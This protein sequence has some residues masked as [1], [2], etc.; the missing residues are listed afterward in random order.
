MAADLGFLEALKGKR[1]V[2]TSHSLGDPD[3]LGA[4]FA[5]KSYL[6][7]AS[8]VPADSIT[9]LSRKLL[10]HAGLKLDE[11]C[12]RDALIVLDCNSRIL[13]GRFSTANTYAVIDHHSAHSDPIESEHKFI[14][15]S[16]SSTCEIVYEYL[17][18]KKFSLEPEIALLLAAGIILDSANFRNSHE[19][20]FT[21]MGELLKLAEIEYKDLMG[22][23]E[24]PRNLSQRMAVLKA[25]QRAKIDRQG[26]YLVATSRVN[27]FESYAA[28]SLLEL[29]ANVSFVGYA[30]RDARIS[31][32]TSLR[33]APKVK[34]TDIMAEAGK[35][36]GGSGGGHPGAA[37][38][39][40]PNADRLDEALDL[41]SKLALQRLK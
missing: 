36:L 19:R 9:A 21:Y 20:T 41:C 15:E 33:L 8:V 17:R 37:G 11:P 29:G 6:G 24:M 2:L 28:E 27:S 4:A 38:A 40:G 26:D 23:L 32:R 14:D 10:E 13:M 18:E 16:Y 7:K 30:G 25:C 3:G 39:T 12:E 22:L 35:L 34:L 5:L 31:A 1:T